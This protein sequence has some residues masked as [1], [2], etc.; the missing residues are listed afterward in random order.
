MS[1]P[2]VTGLIIRAFFDQLAGHSTLGL[3]LWGLMAL[4]VATDL[5][6]LAVLFLATF[7]K[8]QHRFTMRALL[9]HN[10]FVHLLNR[11]GA[12]PVMTSA[13]SVATVSAG[14]AISYFRDDADLI[15]DTIATISEVIGAGVLAIGALA[16]LLSINARMTLL[17]FLPLAVMVVMVEQAQK[18]IKQYRQASRHAT[19][20]VTGFIGEIFSAVQAIK[21]AGAQNQVLSYFQQVNEQRRQRM[22]QDQLFTAMLKS[23]FENLYSIGTGLILLVAAQFMQ[24]GAG[25]LS[26]GDFAVFVFY[27]PYVTYFLEFLGDFLAQ[28]QQTEV[29]FERMAALLSG[30]EAT[31]STRPSQTT[32]PLNPQVD[33]LVAHTPLYLNDLW[34]HRP[35]LPPVDQPHWDE[36]TP[37]HELS[38]HNLTYAYADT[39]QGISGVNLTLRR[40]SLT[41]ITGPVGSGKTT[42]LRVLLGLLPMQ[43][44]AIYWNGDK[45]NDPANFFVPPRSAY[46]PQAPKLFSDSLR[47]NLLL[48]LEPDEPILAQAIT[49]AVFDPDVATMPEGLETR[50]GPRGVRLSGGQ[51]QRTAAAR[52]LVRQPELLVFDD[53]SS[54]LDLETE[55]QLWSRLFPTPPSHDSAAAGSSPSSLA[56][57]PTC[58]VV[59]HRRMVLERADQILVL[60][61]G[62]IVAQGTFAALQ[63]TCVELQML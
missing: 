25:S 17:A 3:S 35:E 49:T 38:A 62:R 10:L 31:H 6:N 14:E 33:A 28:I 58:L 48:G 55:R 36:H 13:E 21:V 8:T 56:Y 15:Q 30:A 24:S 47:G 41:V 50:I 59:S 16:L 27:L 32:R 19:E 22:V 52:M 4:L 26:V 45:V 43:A 53:L 51:V 44:G 20:Q 57:T 60:R 39:G 42:L 5:G 63:A 29:S 54:G 11:P 18:R 34:G 37:L 40:G 1:L 46:T 61:N 2:G 12:L 9:Q 23:A 7:T